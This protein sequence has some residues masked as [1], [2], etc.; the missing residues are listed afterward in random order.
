[1]QI[2]ANPRTI[3]LTPMVKAAPHPAPA[4]I[5]TIFVVLALASLAAGAVTVHRVSEFLAYTA[6]DARR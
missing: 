2:A 5:R 6:A 3:T 4:F 1:M